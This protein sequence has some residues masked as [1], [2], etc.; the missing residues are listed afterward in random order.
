MSE[1]A[2][3]EPKG[4]GNVSQTLTTRLN[5]FSSTSTRSNLPGTHRVIVALKLISYLFLVQ[6]LHDEVGRLQDLIV[7]EILPLKLIS[8]PVSGRTA[9]LLAG[10]SDELLYDKTGTSRNI[11]S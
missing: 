7:R 11:C 3:I 1:N 10:I 2:G 5:L 8:L 9:R 4:G 6:F